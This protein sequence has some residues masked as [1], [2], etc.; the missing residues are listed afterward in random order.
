MP[1]PTPETCSFGT[2]LVTAVV[3]VCAF[4]VGFLMNLLAMSR[5]FVANT[6]CE[7]NR[8]SCGETRFTQSSSLAR[9]VDQQDTRLDKLQTQMTHLHIVLMAIATKLDVDVEALTKN[10]P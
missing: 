8:K 10:F 3:A 1:N 7:T 2:I 9:D 5:M 6:V 4:I